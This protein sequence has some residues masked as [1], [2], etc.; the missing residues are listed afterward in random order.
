MPRLFGSDIV[1]RAD[2]RPIARDPILLGHGD[3]QA[4]VGQLG[5]SVMRDQDVVRVDVAVN[6]P[7][8]VS[9]VQSQGDLPDLAAR[10]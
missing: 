6:Q 10:R 2:R 4:Q 8:A 7:F 3:R 5:R 1:E 9:V